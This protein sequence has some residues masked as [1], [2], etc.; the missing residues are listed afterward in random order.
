MKK[1]TYERTYTVLQVHCNF[2]SERQQR[3]R[4]I[5]QLKC[6]YEKKKNNNNLELLIISCRIGSL[7]SWRQ[8]ASLFMS[9]RA[10]DW[11]SA[12]LN[13]DLFNLPLRWKMK[14]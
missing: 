4:L 8:I 5:L 2:V 6:A 12:Y 9:P 13:L 7:S 10:G 11:I 3:K 14:M 1:K